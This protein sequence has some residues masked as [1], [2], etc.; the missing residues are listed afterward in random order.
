[1]GSQSYALVSGHQ[2]T[3]YNYS[4]IVQGGFNGGFG[5]FFAGRWAHSKWPTHWM[6]SDVICDMTF[7]ELFPVYI[8][9]LLWHPWLSN[10][11]ILYHIDNMA[12]VQVLNTL[13]SKST[14]LMNIVRKLFLLT[15]QHNITIKA[16]HIPTKLNKIADSISRSQWGKFCNLAWEA[17]MWPTQLPKQIWEI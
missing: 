17:E 12:V 8:S 9:L 16:Q 4:Q 10:K 13:T 15:L 14:R 3:V 7:L 2:I 6:F 5:I 11:H 1:M